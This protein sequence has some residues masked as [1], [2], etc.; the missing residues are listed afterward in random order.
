MSYVMQ[1][2]R[3]DELT[4]NT[5]KI[6]LGVTRN[7]H[8]FMPLRSKRS[9]IPCADSPQNTKYHSGHHFLIIFSKCYIC[10]S[11]P[12]LGLTA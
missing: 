8:I 2:E 4:K 11:D 1:P 9:Q 10:M 3:V 12:A 7:F 5:K 6:P